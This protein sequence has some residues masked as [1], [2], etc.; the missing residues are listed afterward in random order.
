[1]QYILTLFFITFSTFSLHAIDID[2]NSSNLSLLENAS[3]FIDKTNKL[4]KEQVIK[5]KFLATHSNIV[6]LGY[7]KETALW[8]K[9]ILT[10][11]SP[12]TIHKILEYDNPE[13]E[14]LSI[15]D[16]NTTTTIGLLYLKKNRESVNPIIHLS[17][18]AYEHKIYYIKSYS[19][20]KSTKAKLILW[21]EIDFIKE[22]SSRQVYR[23]VFFGIMLTLFIYNFMLFLFTK[24]KAY[25]YYI[26]YLASIMCFNAFYS[27]M[28]SL[29]F[30]FQEVSNI[31]LKANVTFGVII[32]LFSL[33]FTQEFLETKKFKRLNRIFNIILLILPLIAILS[34]NNW[35]I[36]SNSLNILILFGLFIIYVGFYSLFKGIKQA[37]FYVLGW[38]IIFIVLSLVGLQATFHYDLRTYHLT[39]IPEVAF[40]VEA[41]LFSIALAHRINLSNEKLIV[42]K[43]EEKKKLEKLV[44]QK[45]KALKISL[46]EK[47]ILYKELNHRIKNNL[48]M[49]LSLLKLQIKRTKNQETISSLT[50]T[51]NRIK[52]ISNL[53]E[54]LLLNNDSININTHSYLEGICN[55]ISINFPKTVKITYKIQYDLKIDNL[56]YMGLIINE[57]ITNSFKYA[58]DNDKGE[59]L[60]KVEKKEATIFV[61]IIDNGKGFKERRKNSLG[62]TIVNI[63]VEGQLQGKLT[64]DSTDGTKIFMKWNDEAL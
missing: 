13:V 41:L 55:N 26:C 53:Y 19:K 21:N 31:L 28:F 8:I 25:F 38:T 51:K 37:R 4:T 44:S 52:S 32:L 27:G 40:I 59:I 17:L 54:M 33:L 22:E 10:N 58:F 30:P 24:D 57:L 15:Y 3:I 18:K 11:K 7:R 48:M 34:Y 62:L 5:K 42:F 49:I 63:L 64:T 16:G 56:I 36:N 20:I 39:Y 61:S 43:N 47:E 6:S 50:V 60:I 45:T 9:V 1:M 46:E 12:K 14:E 29:Y 23:F 2:K 35:I